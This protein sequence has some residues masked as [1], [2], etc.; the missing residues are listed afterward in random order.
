MRWPQTT[1]AV[2]LS[3]ALAACG[4]SRP[5][6]EAKASAPRT[7]AG[8][9]EARQA[10]ASVNQ[11]GFDLLAPNL[12]ASK[13]NVALSPASIATALAMV[14]AG[15]RGT[16]Q[17]EMARVLHVNDPAAI[18]AAINGLQ[19]QLAA[20]NRNNGQRVVD[21]QIANRA[22]AQ[23]GV[24]FEQPFLDVLA[25]SYGAGIGLVD[26]KTATEDARRQINAWVGQQTHNKIPELLAP[27]V[28][29]DLTRLV[30][31][32]AVYL[33]ADWAIPFSKESTA[34][35]AF[36]TNG[37]DVTVP[38]MHGSE[39]RRYATGNGWQ[40]V[41]LDYA[42]QE[43]AMTVLV[44]DPG[45]YDEVV[46]HLSSTVLDAVNGAQPIEVNLALPKFDIQKALTLKKQLSELGMPTAFTDQADFTAMTHQEQL[47]L[48]D[49]VHQATVT[50]D[51]QG[52]VAAAATGA[53]MRN[54]SLTTRSV[55]LVVDRPFV[56]LLRDRPTGAV[57]FAGQVTNPATK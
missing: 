27:G 46:T 5:V 54:T 31:V 35:Q 48:S 18:Q 19:Q 24:A 51:E 1:L 13:G 26:Y 32:N 4:S 15:A 16:T 53:I 23:Q 9:D 40:G 45:R 10:T 3:A 56:F 41:D 55:N 34:S 39:T 12:G 50:V 22:Y 28:L 30:L 47:D 44:P 38:F 2:L 14:L 7:A 6:T 17:A 11:F 42:G 25:R 37:G 36:H 21:L 8:L 57:L 43:L 29:D 49:V 33:K 52:T 20:R